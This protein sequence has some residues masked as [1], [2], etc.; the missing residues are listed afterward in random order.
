MSFIILA[1]DVADFLFNFSE[2]CSNC[3]W[4]VGGGSGEQYLNYTLSV[5]YKLCLGHNLK[6][7]NIVMSICIWVFSIL[8]T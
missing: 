5:G 6:T 7:A 2:I 4:G 8:I 1:M 3:V